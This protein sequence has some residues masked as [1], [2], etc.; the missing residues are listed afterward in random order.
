MKCFD[1]GII[2][3]CVFTFAT[4]ERCALS[5]RSS[6]QLS[7]PRIYYSRFYC[8]RSSLKNVVAVAL[9]TRCCHFNHVFVRS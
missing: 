6:S 4:P 2:P 9:A 7:Q 5:Y 3:S 8:S 1:R